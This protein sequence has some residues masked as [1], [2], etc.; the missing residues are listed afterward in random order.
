M[1]LFDIDKKS[2][3]FLRPEAIKLCPELGVL[4]EQEAITITLA[5]DYYSPYNQFPEEDRQRK[6]LLHVF[7][8]SAPDK[9]FQK[10]K[11]KVAVEAYKGLQYN[12][13]INMIQLYQAKVEDLNKLLMK[14]KDD[15]EINDNVNSIK[16]LRKYIKELEEEVFADRIEEGVV[17][18]KSELS[19]I[20]KMMQNKANWDSITKK[21]T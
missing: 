13:K 20:E 10:E 17:V 8:G 18:G 12:P 7:K 6:A 15:K 21:K 9:F 2:N 4:E 1:Y 5:Y 11:I 16:V 19:W 14:T 3:Q